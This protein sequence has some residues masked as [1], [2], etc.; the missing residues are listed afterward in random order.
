MKVLTKTA[1]GFR[2]GFRRLGAHAKS[3]DVRYVSLLV[4]NVAVR[5]T[6]IGALRD[7]LDRSCYELRPLLE[8][9]GRREQWGA[10]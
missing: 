9:T 4:D 5:S 6:S 2:V 3:E 1:G 7:S 8:K 10:R